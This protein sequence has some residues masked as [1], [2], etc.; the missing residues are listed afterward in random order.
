MSKTPVIGNGTQLVPQALISNPDLRFLPLAYLEK[1]PVTHDWSRLENQHSWS[2]LARLLTVL[3]STDDLS[4]QLLKVSTNI[5]TNLKDHRA[6][7]RKYGKTDLTKVVPKKFDRVLTK[8]GGIGICLGK[9]QGSILAMDH[10]GSVCDLLLEKWRTE[11][12]VFDP[13]MG[14]EQVLPETL[15]FTSGK[16]GRY[17][18]LFYVPEEYKNKITS[19]TFVIYQEVSGV[20]Q[21]ETDEYGKE[22]TAELDFRWS[23]HQSVIY[24]I[25]PQTKQQYQFLNPESPIAVAPNWLLDKLVLV[26]K[27]S[28]KNSQSSSQFLV[29]K[30][31][32]EDHQKSLSNLYE[33]LQQYKAESLSWQEWR[34][35]LLAVDHESRFTTEKHEEGRDTVYA[36]SSLSSKH[37][38]EGFY[39][40]WNHIKDT[41]P[42]PLTGATI[43]QRLRSIPGNESFMRSVVSTNEIKVS[44]VDQKDTL[45]VYFREKYGDKINFLSLSFDDKVKLINSSLWNVTSYKL[46]ACNPWHLRV[47]K[48]ISLEVFVTRYLFVSDLV[49]WNGLFYVYQELNATWTQISASYIEKI[50][51]QF[52]KGIYEVIAS[53]NTKEGEADRDFIR[54]PYATAKIFRSYQDF[55]LVDMFSKE[56][57]KGR[58]YLGFTNGIFDFEMNTFRPFS[59]TFSN[60]NHA[61]YLY[62]QIGFDFEYK[63]VNFEDLSPVFKEFVV[64]AY[65]DHTFTLIQNFIAE[66]LDSE[67]SEGY[68]LHIFGQST[69]GKGT[70][71]RLIQSLFPKQLFND[72]NKL[73]EL[74]TKEDVHQ[75]CAGRRLITLAD[76]QVDTSKSLADLEVFYKLVRN[77]AVSARA[78][79]SKES[80]QQKWHLIFILA[81]ID[82]ALDSN[83]SLGWDKRVLSLPIKDDATRVDL[84]GLDEKLDILLSQ[85]K[86]N[87]ICWSLQCSRK[88]DRDVF[89]SQWKNSDYSAN[90]KKESQD[91]GNSVASFINRC[92]KPSDEPIYTNQD[93]LYEYYSVFCKKQNLSSKGKNHFVK[94]LKLLLPAYH[95]AR[96]AP[97][98]T[99]RPDLSREE[100]MRKQPAFFCNIVLIEDIFLINQDRPSE[101]DMNS[102]QFNPECD[103]ID[104]FTEAAHTTSKIIT[105]DGL[106]KFY[107]PCD[108]YYALQQP[109]VYSQKNFANLPSRNGHK[110]I[111]EIVSVSASDVL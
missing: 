86:Q 30:K 33:V 41:D 21:F 110:P 55:L 98:K 63:P 66:C 19:K 10:D 40:V 47:D 97:K 57:H 37:T 92:C 111:S 59:E 22:Y 18:S 4:S 45:S 54:Y 85:D 32:I 56:Q 88:V 42:D 5:C 39:Q 73:S 71:I 65:G 75:C 99:Q 36:W 7:L 103:G 67:Y 61:K 70:L 93:K 87:I 24:G 74:K 60:S 84:S 12:I 14:Q 69:S 104:L 51:L 68:F 34:D 101:I 8:F 26:T 100:R 94:E 77:E 90:V 81:S 16:Q 83:S 108:D 102:L 15:T 105:K 29:T 1:V 82:N 17:Q 9:D 6:S 95:K 107:F 44:L 109:S 13:E 89:F 38:D 2:D 49:V 62:C 80:Y 96:I 3:T 46:E 25:H 28:A 72:L 11:Q 78:L 31:S 91:S 53:K 27:K 43:C 48:G 58:K 23:G 64:S 106:K 76:T 35:V 20:S 79:Y 52:L 50:T